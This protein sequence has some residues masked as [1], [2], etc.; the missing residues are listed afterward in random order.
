MKSA[1]CRSVATST[2]VTKP[3]SSMTFRQLEDAINK[4]TLELDEQENIFLNQATQVNAWDRL[5][6]D[7]G[8]KVNFYACTMFLC[9][10][11]SV[12]LSALYDCCNVSSI[13][14]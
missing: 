11:V 6:I 8:E 10:F 7:N 9:L 5:L 4:W 2:T 12:H 1:V 13:T 3:A 14:C